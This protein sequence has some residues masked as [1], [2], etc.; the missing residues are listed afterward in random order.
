MSP[1]TGEIG[2][3]GSAWVL[4][5]RRMHWGSTVVVS[6]KHPHTQH[7]HRNET[8]NM[9]RSLHHMN[10]VEKRAKENPTIYKCHTD[11]GWRLRATCTPRAPERAPQRRST[12][13]PHT[14]AF[15]IAPWSSG[16]EAPSRR[17]VY[18]VGGKHGEADTPGQSARARARVAGEWEGAA[19]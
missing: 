15:T 1:P 16:K 14:N 11:D 10:Y 17:N 6:R 2:K 8:N 5:G 19:M 7:T 9:A 4:C 18:P 12:A 13:H 3:Q